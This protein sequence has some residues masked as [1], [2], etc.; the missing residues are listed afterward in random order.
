MLTLIVVHN[1]SPNQVDQR[2]MTKGRNVKKVI[3]G[4]YYTVG[5]SDQL[6]L[7]PLLPAIVS[8]F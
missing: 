8:V 5:H 4:S 1:K 2:Q 3:P 6:N 7:T